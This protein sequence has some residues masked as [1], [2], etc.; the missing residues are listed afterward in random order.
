VGRWLGDWGGSPAATRHLAGLALEVSDVL[1]IKVIRSGFAGQVDCGIV[2]K[3]HSL[4]LRVFR[5]WYERL[6]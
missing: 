3:E 5:R 1:G 6:V 4:W 2:T